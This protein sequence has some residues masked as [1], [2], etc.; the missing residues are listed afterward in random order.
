L[1]RQGQGR[2]FEREGG[3][4]DDLRDSYLNGRGETM[5]GNVLGSF[6]QWRKA[7]RRRRRWSRFNGKGREEIFT[8][9]YRENFW[10]SKES[11]SG[12][13]SELAAT[14]LVRPFLQG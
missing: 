9:I 14:A 12:T 3:G 10:R 11:V 4:G 13:G 1:S 6:K 2:S 7:R 8:T 5:L